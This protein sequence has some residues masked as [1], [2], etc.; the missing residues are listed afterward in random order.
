MHIGA[1]ALHIGALAFAIDKLTVAL[2]GLW[3]GPKNKRAEQ[4]VLQR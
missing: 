2:I 3:C 1:L 4:V